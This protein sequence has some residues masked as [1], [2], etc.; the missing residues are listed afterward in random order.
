MYA[1]IHNTTADFHLLISLYAIFYVLELIVLFGVV[2]I[3][4]VIHLA[5]K[6]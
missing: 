5:L 4:K 3:T 6:V 1:Y 2:K